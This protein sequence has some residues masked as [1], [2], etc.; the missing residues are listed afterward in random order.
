[1][2]G[3]C[4]ERGRLLMI[5]WSSVLPPCKC[6]GS[7]WLHAIDRAHSRR[8]DSTMGGSVPLRWCGVVLGQLGPALQHSRV[9]TQPLIDVPRVEWFLGLDD[10]NH[11]VAR[12]PF[13][14]CGFPPL[15]Q[16]RVDAIDQRVAWCQGSFHGHGAQRKV[17][18]CMMRERGFDSISR[19]VRRH[20]TRCPPA[21]VLVGIG[22]SFRSRE[23]WGGWPMTSWVRRLAGPGV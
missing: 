21:R 20:Q 18:P 8:C 23:T 7:P 17:G 1:M 6:V 22:Q 3:V 9:V 14:G 2:R 5:S 12:A 16:R 10:R 19:P 15:F 4:Y 13:G 11:G